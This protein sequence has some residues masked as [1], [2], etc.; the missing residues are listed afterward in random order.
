[1]FRCCASYF[2]IYFKIMKMIEDLLW[3]CSK[4]ESDL[5]GQ[6]LLSGE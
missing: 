3:N 4:C 2:C 5:H 6:C 1:M